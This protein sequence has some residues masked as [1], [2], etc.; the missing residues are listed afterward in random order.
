MDL[1]ARQNVQKHSQSNNNSLEA[2]FLA[3]GYSTPQNPEAAVMFGESHMNLDF[4]S[5]G[6]RSLPQGG[7]AWQ[8]HNISII[9]LLLGSRL[10]SQKAS[11]QKGHGLQAPLDKDP[12][13]RPFHGITGVPISLFRL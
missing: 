13:Q 11:G 6:H 8:V 12:K 10:C 4:L 2:V 9:G 5:L 1:A 3:K 7:V